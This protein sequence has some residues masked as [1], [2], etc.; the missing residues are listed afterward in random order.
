MPVKKEVKDLFIEWSKHKVGSP[1]WEKISRVLQNKW[2]FTP[3]NL[4][5][6]YDGNNTIEYNDKN[7]R[8]SPNNHQ[9]YTVRNLEK[10]T[11]FS[12]CLKL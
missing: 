10:F 9:S 1:E 8:T 2:G 4:L 7:I 5:A 3:F 11:E 6:F 12:R